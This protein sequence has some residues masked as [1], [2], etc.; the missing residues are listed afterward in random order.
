MKKI[1]LGIAAFLVVLSGGAGAG[2]ALLGGGSGRINTYNKTVLNAATAASTTASAVVNI[3]SFA[4]LYWTVG[5]TSASATIKFACSFADSQPTFTDARTATNTWDYIDITDVEDESSI[6]GD[7]GVLLV[8][9]STD[10]RLFQMENTGYKWCTTFQ[11]DWYEGTLKVT[12]L[13]STN[14]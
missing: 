6:D 10:T 12:V 13:G 3:G 2:S 8:S 5:A 11:T 1:L 14:Y 9:G 7:T 4:Q